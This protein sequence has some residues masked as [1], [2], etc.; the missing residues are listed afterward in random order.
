MKKYEPACL[1]I[2]IISSFFPSATSPYTGAPLFAQIPALKELA[3]IRVFC[4]RSAYPPLR[5]LQPRKHLYRHAA[6]DGYDLAGVDAVHIPFRTVPVVGRAVNGYLGGRAVFS[7][8]KEFAPDL[9]LS[10]TVYPDGYGAL[11][12]GKKLGVPVVLF[13]IGSDVRYVPDRV[14]KRLV[15]SALQR[16]DYVLAVSHELLARA[17]DQGARPGDSLAI[18]NGCDTTIFRPQAREAMR[19][20]LGVQAKKKEIVFVGRLVPLKGLREL[21]DA[22]A[23]VK[24]QCPAVEFTCI[25]EGPL[26]EELRARAAR[27]DLAGVVR[28][29]ARATPSEIADWMGAADITCLAS[30]TEGC[31]NAIVESLACGRAVVATNVGGIP[32]L[33]NTSNGILVRPHDP[34]D[35]ARGLIDALAGQWDEAAIAAASKRSWGDVARE[36]I[37][38]CEQ[39]LLRKSLLRTGSK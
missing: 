19:A 1:R 8:V 38:V 11:G 6:K 29:V 22:L 10:Y 21:F 37:D 12:V 24:T 16:A 26:G 31:P 32:E 34:E 13:A 23:I 27:E 15:R 9:I 20:R 17:L 33:V 35:L 7:A 30:Y 3:E 4:P 36:T 28:F 18:L 39:V 14:Q 25:G 2:A 5:F